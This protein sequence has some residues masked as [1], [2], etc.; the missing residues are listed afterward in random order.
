MSQTISVTITNPVVYEIP[1]T[2][3]HAVKAIWKSGAD[4]NIAVM[5]VAECNDLEMATAR[6]ICWRIMEVDNDKA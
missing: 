6:R 1:L 2:V 4:T 3:Y 5:L